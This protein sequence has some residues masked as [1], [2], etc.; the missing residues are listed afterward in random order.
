DALVQS[1]AT[2]I[3]GE[4]RNVTRDRRVL[5]CEWHNSALRN[6][7]G[8]VEA[9]FS[10]ALD[11]TERKQA[12]EQLQD[13][14]QR[15]DVFIATLAHELRNPLAPIA[16]AASLLLS[17]RS[18]HER[19]EWIASMISRQSARMGRLLDDLL[20][21]SRISRG[22]IE[23]RKEPVE[24]IGLVQEALQ[25]SQPLVE[26]ARHH[27]EVDLP[28]EPVWID[29]DP[30]R[31]AQIMSNLV[32]NAAKYTP[33]GGRIE[34]RLARTNDSSVFTVRDNGI[35][36]EPDMLAH[37]FE[38]FVQVGSARHL[39]QGGLG[40]G[41]S[42]AQGLAELHGGSLEVASEGRDRGSTFTLR[43]PLAGEQSASP[44]HPGKA[45][46]AQPASQPSILVADDNVDA[47]DSLALLLR[48]RGAR[49]VVAYD[50]EEAL[51][52]FSEDPT[53]VVIL[54]LGMPCVDGLAAARQL[55]DADPRPFLIALT[56]RGRKEDEQESLRAGF[57]EHLI[58]PV[59]LDRLEAILQ[60]VPLPQA[61]L[62]AA[63]PT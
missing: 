54:D 41:L 24:M 15:K 56:G 59:D 9:I 20:D 61:G 18:D 42:L 55:V 35:G 53:D 27:V 14:D 12:M 3:T 19:V 17:Q 25:V 58:K 13:A 38:A 43:L 8:E 49:V 44:E 21:V 7:R 29:A 40:I 60:R 6:E 2:Y 10:L 23:L 5:Q 22:K 34:V 50:G 57:N 26:A 47:V 37:V 32:N 36:I 1:S 16:N 28:D 48:A 52:K 45:S 46:A 62:S 63:T 51:Q 11:I 4:N 33:P 39:A 30:V 31:I